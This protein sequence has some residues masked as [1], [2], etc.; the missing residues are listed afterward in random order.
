[1]MLLYSSC[2][3]KDIVDELNEQAANAQRF[4]V[5]GQIGN[6]TINLILGDSIYTGVTT[7]YPL[8]DGLNVHRFATI[9]KVDN[10]VGYFNIDVSGKAMG[11]LDMI[12]DLKNG[13]TVGGYEFLY[14]ED[15]SGIYYGP[16][17]AEVACLYN[18][19]WYVSSRLKQDTKFNI[20]SAENLV[21]DGYVYRVITASFTCRLSNINDTT[22]VIE[23]NKG[24]ARIAFGGIAE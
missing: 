14:S 17:Q 20:V 5:R 8:G 22:D 21:E 13:I 2:E 7:I 12:D 24:E 1:M 16:H 10:L 11:S 23:L 9:N 18:D 19:K 15:G 3:K 4:Y 6:E